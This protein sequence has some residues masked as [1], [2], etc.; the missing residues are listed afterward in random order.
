MHRACLRLSPAVPPQALN[1]LINW[2]SL[3]LGQFK[4]TERNPF[5][6]KG[7]QSL[8]KAVHRAEILRKTLQDSRLQTKH[9]VNGSPLEPLEVCGR[10]K[11]L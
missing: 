1:Q 10:L 6:H 4:G 3:L 8:L 7:M 2:S 9:K 11:E 5:C